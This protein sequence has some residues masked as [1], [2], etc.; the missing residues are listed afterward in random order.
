MP[1]NVFPGMPE[2]HESDFL[3]TLGNICRIWRDLCH[4]LVICVICD[5]D[6]CDLWYLW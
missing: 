1:L 5:L 3:A 6:L 4:F 2:G